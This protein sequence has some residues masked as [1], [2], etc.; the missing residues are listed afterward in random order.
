[1]KLVSNMLIQDLTVLTDIPVL[2]AISD[3]FNTCPALPA[4]ILYRQ[5]FPEIHRAILGKWLLPKWFFLIASDLLQRLSEIYQPEISA[6]GLGFLEPLRV[7]ICNSIAN[8]Y[9]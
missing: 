5:D 7:Q 9:L 2:F 8:L 3:R 6:C 4:Q 1:M